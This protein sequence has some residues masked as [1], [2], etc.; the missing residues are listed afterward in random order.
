MPRASQSRS[1][2]QSEELCRPRRRSP[3]FFL[4]L[5]PTRV[6]LADP[7]PELDPVFTELPAELDQLTFALGRKDDEPLERTFQLDPHAVQ[8]RYRFQHL[9]LGAADCFAGLLITVATIVARPIAL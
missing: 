7:V 9:E 2:S 6:A 3:S 4:E 1:T 8:S 5:L